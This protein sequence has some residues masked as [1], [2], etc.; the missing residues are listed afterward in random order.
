M[1]TELRRSGSEIHFVLAGVDPALRSAVHDLAFREVD[2]EFVRS[3]PAEAEFVDRAYAGFAA[4]AEEMALQAA[5]I[6][7]APWDRALEELLGRTDGSGVDWWLAGSGALAARGLDVAP[8]DL[9]VIV[10]DD[11]ARQLAELL[12]D[13]LVDP[14]SPVT[15]WICNWWGRAFLHARIEWVGG[16]GPQV[17]EPAVADFGPTAARSLET[18]TWR[19]RRVR[20]P[21]LA[22][23]LEVC[24]RRGL[25]DRAAAI[26]EL[27]G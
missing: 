12:A 17:D 24:E 5:G 26:R 14:L 22:L 4:H 2:G 15:G 16:V 18:V 9:D 11:G 7:P 19:D 13:V 1:R 23:Q 6:R 21:P 8:R 25:A 10:D 3:F 27:L 20:V